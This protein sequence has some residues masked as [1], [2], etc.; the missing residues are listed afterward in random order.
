MRQK[1]E[2]NMNTTPI[3]R[4]ITCLIAV[5]TLLTCGLIGCSK[6]ETPQTPETPDDTPPANDPETPED[7]PKEQE[8]VLAL[9]T[10]GISNYKVI[11]AESTS[12]EIRQALITLTQAVQAA[13]GC[14][15]TPGTD[16]VDRGESVPTDTLEILI[17]ET[18]RPESIAAK[19]ALAETEY[20]ITAVG[21]RLVIVGYD[22]ACTVAAVNAFIE[23]MAQYVKT[24]D[25]KTD[26]TFPADYAHKGTYVVK[27]YLNEFDKSSLSMYL[28][29]K[30]IATEEPL[31]YF[32]SFEHFEYKGGTEVDGYVD[33]GMSFTCEKDTP[34]W[35]VINTP[36]DAFSINVENKFT[37][38]VKMWVYVNDIDL[39]G[40]D[41]DAVYGTPQ[42]GS[43][44]LYITLFDKKG[45]GHTW[46]HTFFGSGWHEIELSF[47]CHNIAYKDLDKIDYSNLDR[48]SI[49]CIGYA[50][51]EL[52]FDEMRFCTYENP[53]Y[54]RPEAPHGGRWLSTC[55]YEALDGPILTEWYGSYFDL[56]DKTQGSSSVAI[57]GHKENVDHRVCIGVD[58]VP[59]SY[60][61]DTVCF[62]MYISD[63]NLLGTNWQI[64]LEHNAQAGFYFVDYNV[65]KGC[66]VDENGN[67]V[68]LR[69]GAWN[70]IRL[71]LNKT[72]LNIGAGYEDVLDENLTL[73]QL[74]FF[75]QG[76][77]LTEKE[78]YLIKYDNFYVA[79]TA[80][81]EAAK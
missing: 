13:T 46:Q 59:V 6:P 69:S 73:T 62:D 28:D 71:P 9:V 23:Q 24:A 40:C 53:G 57:V 31:L 50:G 36:I 47:N 2:C 35:S 25:G 64:R 81:L 42:V 34:H 72:T 4:W 27:S 41:H 45:N 1:G 49:W 76:T 21:K 26:L 22:E 37:Q 66:A 20:S 11:R 7:P 51:L 48:M 33:E 56:E 65:L 18:N 5:L 61:E 12:S 10:R 52:I 15:L 79:K 68:A 63:L 38:T 75:I 58:N 60:N 70:H 44:T 32:D 67:P 78:N 77:G 29:D 16:W 54:V 74:M 55:D 39:L 17:G 43:G 19:E 80:D 14:T 30:L 8:E 3:L